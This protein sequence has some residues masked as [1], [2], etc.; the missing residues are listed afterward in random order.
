MEGSG[1]SG[2]SLASVPLTNGPGWVREIQPLEDS[3][4]CI[5]LASSLLK[6]ACFG[7][8]AFI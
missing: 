5:E 7:N 8:A 3:G 1:Y 2:F 6:T 4:R